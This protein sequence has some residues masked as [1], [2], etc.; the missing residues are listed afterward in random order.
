MTAITKSRSSAGRTGSRFQVA[1]RKIVLVGGLALFTIWTVFPL[2][3]I[4][5]TS[6][7]TNKEIYSDATLIPHQLTGV[8]YAELFQQTLFLTYF[9]NSLIVASLTTLISM[10]IGICAA[11]AI[12]RLDFRERISSRAPRLSPILC[13]VRC[14][15]SRC[16]RLPTSFI[17]PTKL[18]G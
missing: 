2:I 1:V 16:F 11:Y 8:H 10:V 13:P 17:S 7:K 6:V 3:W 4:V 12:T 15:S 18:W 9:K 5:E 14:C